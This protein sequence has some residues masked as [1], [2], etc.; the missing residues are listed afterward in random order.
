MGDCSS[1]TRLKRLTNKEK[2]VVFWWFKAIHICC[3]YLYFSR[4]NNIHDYR[5]VHGSS[6][7]L[8]VSSSFVDLAWFSITKKKKASMS[9]VLKAWFGV[10]TSLPSLPEE[11]ERVVQVYA[12]LGGAYLGKMVLPTKACC[13]TYFGVIREIQRQGAALLPHHERPCEYLT[14][15]LDGNCLPSFTYTS[16]ASS[17]LYQSM[18]V[19]K[20]ATSTSRLE[21]CWNDDDSEVLNVVNAA[22]CGPWGSNTLNIE[23][24]NSYDTRLLKVL[25]FHYSPKAV[26]VHQSDDTRK[27]DLAFLSNFK[28]L[29][30]ITLNRVRVK[31]WGWLCATRVDRLDLNLFDV[32]MPAS[33]FVGLRVK[34]LNIFSNCHVD[35]CLSALEGLSLSSFS[36]SVKDVARTKV[37]DYKALSNLS[38]EDVSI[39]FTM[40]NSQWL[41]HWDSNT[42]KWEASRK[43]DDPP[44]HASDVKSSEER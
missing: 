30:D 43:E 5:M 6:A 44:S 25:T 22:C 7:T 34:H 24:D 29:Q 16:C 19:L 10:V 3:E 23:V 39:T 12:K 40:S 27:V 2:E 32:W 41:H 13:K 37:K 1:Q 38:C 11:H 18:D 20:Q 8:F 28:A 26:R 21:L 15:V 9:L 36:I 42:K 4:C 35:T 17:L 31:S 14:V 33:A